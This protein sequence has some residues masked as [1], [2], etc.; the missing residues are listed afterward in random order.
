MGGIYWLASYHKSGNTWLRVFLTNLINNGEKPSDINKLLTGNIASDRAWL[1]H[2]IGFDTAELSHEEV[3]RIRP[4]VYKWSLKQN[5]IGYHKIH[6]AYTFTLDGIPLVSREATIGALYIIRNPLDIAPSAASHWNCSLEET[7]EIMCQSNMARDD[8]R[9]ALP[10]QVRQ[11]MGSWSEHVLSWVDAPNLDIEV[12]R[13]EDMLAAPQET[14][15]RAAI[16]L[17]LPGDPG[18]IAKAINF[19]AFEELARQEAANGFREKRHYRGI[20]FNKGRSGEGKNTLS[21]RQINRL[22]TTHAKVMERFCYI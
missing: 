9:E 7:V 15:T 8:T 3:E 22:I 19:S 18:R 5:S 4:E 6:D 10:R 13:Y 16:F 11:R 14:F 20:F 21:A 1:D 17:N 12:I 2:V